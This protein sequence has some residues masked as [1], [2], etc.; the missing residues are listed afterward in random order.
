MNPLLNARF[1]LAASTALALGCSPLPA[2]KP[3]SPDSNPGSGP[4]LSVECTLKPV[5]GA[6][7]GTCSV[8]CSVNALAIDFVGVEK[9][10]ACQ[11]PPRTV[12]ASLK[13]TEVAHRWL[14]SMQGVQPEDPTRWELVPNKSTAG[15]TARTPFGWFEVVQLQ[16]QNEVLRVQLNASRQLRPTADDLAIIQRATELLPNAQVWN[17]NDTRQC[18]PGA[19]KL[20]LFCALM[21]ATTEVSGGVH[22]RQPAMQA[23]REE[24]N[25]VDASRIKTHRIMDYNNHADTSLAEVHALLQRAKA[26]VVREMR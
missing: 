8:P 3:T 1:W 7:A 18:P 5:A 15:H 14:G 6:Y 2:P 10:R 23:V 24:L 17:K 16:E 22:Y 11:G 20:S 9:T 19:Q 12:E 26:R 13:R 4:A 25:W 21:Q